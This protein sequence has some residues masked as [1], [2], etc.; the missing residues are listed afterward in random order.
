MQR[1]ERFV[2]AVCRLGMA[3][4]ALALL[5]SLVLVGFG[6]FERYV[7]DTPVPWT[8][9]LVGYLLVVSVMLAAGGAL[10]DDEHIGVDILTEKLST[11]GKHIAFVFGLC[12]VG[13]TGTLLAIDGYGMVSFSQAVGLRSNGYLAVPMWVP[14]LFVPVGAVILIVATVAALLRALRDRSSTHKAPQIPT[15]IE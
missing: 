7:L 4:S 9:E 2:R 3:I 1:F 10:L 14:E 13:A 6:V 15:G 5:A 11:R 12:A 8:D